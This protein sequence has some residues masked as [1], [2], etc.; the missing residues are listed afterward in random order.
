MIDHL[1]IGAKDFAAS[2]RFYE[3]A[4]APLVRQTFAELQTLIAVPAAG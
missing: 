3:A 1:G 4:F 2:R